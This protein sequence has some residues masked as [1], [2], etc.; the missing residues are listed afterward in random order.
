[1]RHGRIGGPEGCGAEGD[2]TSHEERGAISPLGPPSCP[3]SPVGR[4]GPRS[5]SLICI[6]RRRPGSSNRGA[7]ETG[8]SGPVSA[9]STLAELARS[10]RAQVAHIAGYA[11]LDF[12]S[13]FGEREQIAGLLDSSV[14]SAAYSRAVLC[15]MRADGGGQPDRRFRATI[16]TLWCG[17][18]RRRTDGA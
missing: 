1:M 18:C 3:V 7:T 17:R 4:A 15:A 16:R 8:W 12:L 14:E 2:R 13:R 5:P 10:E 6:G 11:L 9:S